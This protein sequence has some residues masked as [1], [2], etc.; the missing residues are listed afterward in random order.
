MYIPIQKIDENERA[1]MYAFRVEEWGWIRFSIDRVSG[2][3]RLEEAPD[4]PDIE[5]YF[6]RASRRVRDLSAEGS[7]PVRTCWVS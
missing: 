3:T 2:T 4:A 1:A 7:F 6:A 5:G